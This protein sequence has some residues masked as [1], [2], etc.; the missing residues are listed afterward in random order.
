M[1]PNFKVPHLGRTPIRTYLKNVHKF[2]DYYLNIIMEEDFY[3]PFY[4]Y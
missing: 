3:Y 4:S 2:N 1:Y